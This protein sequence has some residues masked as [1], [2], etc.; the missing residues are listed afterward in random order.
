[1]R[2]EEGGIQRKRGKGGG[3]GGLMRYVCCI[4]N[5]TWPCISHLASHLRNFDMF[6]SS[7]C[8]HSS[9]YP[10]RASFP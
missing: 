1:M 7:V 9:P 2:G 3:E 4:D 6:F 10:G 5:E 8:D